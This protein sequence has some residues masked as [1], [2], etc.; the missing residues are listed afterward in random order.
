MEADCRSHPHIAVAILHDG[1]HGVARE[2]GAQRRALD[3]CVLIC[4]SNTPQTIAEC[5]NPEHVLPVVHQSIAG[6]FKCVRWRTGGAEL[7]KACCNVGRPDVSL[8]VLVDSPHMLVRDDAESRRA[9]D[10]LEHAPASTDPQRAGAADEHVTHLTHARL[11]GQRHPMPSVLVPPVQIPVNDRPYRAATV[12]DDGGDRLEPLEP[13]VVALK[14]AV[15]DSSDACR[16][17]RPDPEP[18]ALRDGQ[19]FDRPSDRRVAEGVPVEKS[20]AVEAEEAGIGADP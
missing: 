3:R 2:A 15:T 7:T 8:A 6:S 16:I 1:E 19:C 12:F 18:A 5:A 17:C 20:P 9:C 14:L 11:P 13:G 10:L 4:R